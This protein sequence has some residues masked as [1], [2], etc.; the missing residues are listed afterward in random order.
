MLEFCF[1]LFGL[2]Y[3]DT[4]SNTVIKYEEVN[5]QLVGNKSDSGWGNQI[6]EDF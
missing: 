2:K 1:C 3:N 4:E 5:Q 6:T